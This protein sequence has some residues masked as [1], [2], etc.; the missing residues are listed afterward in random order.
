VGFVV[1]ET[2]SDCLRLARQDPGSFE[3]CD[4]TKRAGTRASRALPAC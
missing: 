1:G 3:N 4:R 2:T